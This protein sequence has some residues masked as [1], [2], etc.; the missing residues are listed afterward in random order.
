MKQYDPIDTG[1][2]VMGINCL[3]LTIP[4]LA[5]SRDF[6]VPLRKSGITTWDHLPQVLLNIEH[7][8]LRWIRMLWGPLDVIKPTRR[9]T[10]FDAR[11]EFGSAFRK[12]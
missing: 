4:I 5:R 7:F 2:F 10:N 12:E 11:P 3:S 8:M 6:E 1:A 9:L